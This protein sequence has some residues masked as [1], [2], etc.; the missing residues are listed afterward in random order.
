MNKREDRS[1]KKE[2]GKR[3]EGEITFFIQNQEA[4]E[5]RNP[6][7]HGF[8]LSFM[9]KKTADNFRQMLTIKHMLSQ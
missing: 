3:E 8:F 6:F 1:L 9:P 2:T 5:E 4:D 7:L